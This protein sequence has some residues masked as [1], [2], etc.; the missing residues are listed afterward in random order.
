[1]RTASYIDNHP[2]YGP[3]KTHPPV[4]ARIIS[5]RNQA[6]GNFSAKL[7]VGG[8]VT[9]VPQGSTAFNMKSFRNTTRELIPGLNDFDPEAPGGSKAFVQPSSAR[10]DSQGRIVMKV[11][12][13]QEEASLVQKELMGETKIFGQVPKAEEPVVVGDRLRKKLSGG[14]RMIGSSSTYGLN[15]LKR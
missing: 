2:V 6:S 11:S 12:E 13:A 9:E 15:P 4:K 14:R 7:G 5:P 10:V 8:F 1:L 3:Q